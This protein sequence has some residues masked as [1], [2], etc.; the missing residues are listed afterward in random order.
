MD[1]NKITQDKNFYNLTMNSFINKNN[2]RDANLINEM[3]RSHQR[4]LRIEPEI[5][6]KIRVMRYFNNKN[7]STKFF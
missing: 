2:E 6:K 3:N 7:N 4:K 1:L 5:E